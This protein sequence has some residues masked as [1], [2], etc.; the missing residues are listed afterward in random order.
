MGNQ[1]EAI[2]KLYAKKKICKI[3]AKARDGVEQIEVEVMPLSLEDMGL[4]NVGDE[5]SLSE[6]SKNAKLMF[7]KSLGITEDDASKISTEFMED[8]LVAIIGVNN[9]NEKDMQ[10]T[11]IKDFLKKKREQIKEQKGEENGKPTGGT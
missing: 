4:L 10:K 3:P 11:G 1:L 6:L 2:E 8:L 7:S 5:L 9:F